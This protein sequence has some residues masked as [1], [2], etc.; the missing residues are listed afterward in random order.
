MQEISNNSLTNGGDGKIFVSDFLVD[1][2]LI[3][4]MNMNSRINIKKTLYFI[5]IPFCF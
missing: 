2:E 4:M 3:I 5:V 1:P